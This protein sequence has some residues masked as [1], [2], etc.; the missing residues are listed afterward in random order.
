MDMFTKED[1][2]RLMDTQAWPHVSIYIPT[3]RESDQ[4]QQDP[5]R[6]KNLLKA[7][8]QHLL[9]N[10]RMKPSEAAEILK[11][12]LKL[13]DDQ[14]FWLHQSDGLALFLSAEEASYY[15]LP[16]SFEE[17]VVVS[18]GFHIK[19]LLPLFNNDGRF[20]ILALSQNNIRLLS[21]TRFTVD[22]INL[23]G[24]P[25]SLAEAMQHDDPERQL[26]HH[27]GEKVDTTASGIFHGHGVGAGDFKKDN[28]L[29]FFQQVDK[30]IRTLLEN[31]S[32]PLVL[33]GVDYLLPIYRE[34]SKYPHLID[35]GVIG[36]PDEASAQELH[37]QA[38]QL[39]QPYFQE[40]RKQATAEYRQLADSDNAS[41]DLPEIVRA[42]HY[43]RVKV[44][45]VAADVQRWGKFDSEKNILE[46]HDSP[47]PGDAELLDSVV[48]QTLMHGGTVYSAEADEIPGDEPVAAVF[49]Y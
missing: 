46:V 40:E 12:A 34:A 22:Q 19:P 8:E 31:Q 32:M 43:G 16:Y 7:A 27:I 6:L 1:L 10:K 21:G 48:V 15:R 41:Q 24:V 45:F 13:L 5:I 44:A 14:D 29:R 36:N 39:I 35:E 9:D 49:R 42:A 26:Q 37:E 47:E 33:A 23:E 11:P 20:Y 38:W 25:T 3:H 18:A 30:G 17:L 28:I 2:E 4:A